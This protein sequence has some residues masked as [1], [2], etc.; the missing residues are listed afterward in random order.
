MKLK[1]FDI[2]AAKAG[3]RVV[4]EDGYP[5]RILCFDMK[6]PDGFPLVGLVTTNRDTEHAFTWNE[7]GRVGNFMSQYAK[8]LRMATIIITKFV[9]R[10]RVD[11]KEEFGSIFFDTER[12]AEECGKCSIS[13]FLGVA[14]V[15]WEE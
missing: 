6:N 5:V 3:A 14:K 2:E 15:E 7:S 10:Y 4:T 8:D 11:G 9:T 13:N 1:P 12:E